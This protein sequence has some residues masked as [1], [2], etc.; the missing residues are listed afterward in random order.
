M[1][2][3]SAL[4]APWC[5]PEQ[6]NAGSADNLRIGGFTGL[7]SIDFPG[8]LA[9]VVFCQG[10]PWRC[11][12]C[13][14]T[15]LL[16][17]AALTDWCWLDVESRLHERRGLLDG[18][19]FSGGDPTLQAALPDALTRVRALGFE[20]GL[21]TA[22]MYPQRLAALLPMLNW[23]GLDIK[24][25]EDRYDAITRTPH[26]GE[27]AWNSLRELVRSGVAYEC[28]TTWHRGLFAEDELEA[29]AARLADEGVTHWALQACRDP[30][31]PSRRAARVDPALAQR[32]GARFAHFV[33]RSD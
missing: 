13:Q 33:L 11:C 30:S 25:P 32:L 18:V 12:Y 14:N 19:V 29:L 6:R 28:R 24:A 5:T 22:G 8:R 10:C 27:K 9:A 2:A 26:S 7:T 16:D 21:H 23:V 1:T 4:D 3:A 15:S 31:W 20:T 17:A